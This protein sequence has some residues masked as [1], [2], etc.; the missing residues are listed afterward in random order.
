MYELKNPQEHIQFLHNIYKS[1]ITTHYKCADFISGGQEK[2]FNNLKTF[3]VDEIP[4]I[5]NNY[6]DYDTYISLNQFK[7]SSRKTANIDRVVSLGFDL[8]FRDGTN[9]DV[10]MNDILNRTDVLP[11]NIFIFSGRGIWPVYLLNP[12]EDVQ[13]YKQ[14]AKVIASKLSNYPIDYSCVGDVSRITRLIGTTNTSVDRM[15]TGVVTLD[16]R[17][18]LDTLKAFYP[19]TNTIEIGHPANTPLKVRLVGED[20]RMQVP[21]KELTNL[22]ITVAENRTSITEG[23]RNSFLFYLSLAVK[24][25]CKLNGTQNDVGLSTV[26]NYNEQY[27]LPHQDTR[28]V[29]ATYKCVK[30]LHPFSYVSVKNKLSITIQE[31]I[32]AGI[33]ID[34]LFTLEELLPYYD[35]CKRPTKKL[36]RVLM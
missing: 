19:T 26:I 4:T 5:L 6:L 35:Y 1:I 8:D 11:F 33:K 30:T 32:L 12:T 14:V 13:S 27:C 17:Y 28:D 31:F 24:S 15:V 21:Y 3:N 2:K 29:V 22:L 7:S 20:E 9:L 10:V 36:L 16:S 18:D 25:L 34:N 23:Y